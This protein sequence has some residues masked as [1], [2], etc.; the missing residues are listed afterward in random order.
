MANKDEKAVGG[1]EKVAEDTVLKMEQP[2]LEEEQKGWEEDG[3]K[4][5]VEC[6]VQ[7]EEKQWKDK[8]H[9]K[10]QVQMEHQAKQERLVKAAVMFFFL[11]FF[12]CSLKFGYSSEA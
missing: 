5:E 6:K 10:Q 4:R 11:F 9:R 12:W 2:G 3:V 7:E 8:E 1:V